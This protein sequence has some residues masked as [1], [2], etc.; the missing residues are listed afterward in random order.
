[1]ILI[2][3]ANATSIKI[4]AEATTIKTATASKTAS[5]TTAAESSGAT[6]SGLRYDLVG[7]T[8]L[9]NIKIVIFFL[10]IILNSTER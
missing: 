1:M 8:K 4:T 5:T 9:A 2:E 10:N 6:M 3:A 7:N